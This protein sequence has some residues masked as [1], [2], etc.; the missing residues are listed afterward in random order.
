MV[1]NQSGGI[2]VRITAKQK[3]EEYKAIEK[4]TIDN[5]LTEIYRCIHD[6]KSVECESPIYLKKGNLI[7]DKV[8]SR[9][10]SDGFSIINRRIDHNDV[11]IISWAHLLEKVEQEER[12]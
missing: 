3:A 7:D 5:M 6:A 12:S 10:G 11:T 2:I 9:L 1:Q 4:V 8:M